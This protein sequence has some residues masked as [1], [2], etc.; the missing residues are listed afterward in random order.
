MVTSDF[1]FLFIEKANWIFFFP[2]LPFKESSKNKIPVKFLVFI[3]SR[4]PL[5]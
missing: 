2:R 3:S 1:S 4:G 5:H